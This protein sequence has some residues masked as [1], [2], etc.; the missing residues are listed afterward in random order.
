MY[1]W[2]WEVMYTYRSV[3]IHG[4]LE[5]MILTLLTVLIGTAGGIIIAIVRRSENP[6]FSVMAKIGIDLIRA[7]PILVLLIWA[8]YVLP[9]L[10][11][12]KL[13]PFTTATFTL[14]LHLSAFVAETI[15]AGVESIP[16]HQFESAEALGLTPLQTMTQI[17]APQAIRNILPNVLGLYVTQIKNTSLTSV[18]AVNELLHVSN[19][20][21][22]ASYRPLEI[23]TVVACIYVALIEPCEIGVHFLE[24]KFRKNI[25][26]W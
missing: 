16:K 7:L 26:V 1:T 18:I 15:R 13:S 8:F 17:I 9:L 23:Y 6:V 21:I 3:F 24:R 10:T 4:A 14:S 5:T 22:S 20:L 2:N 12:W 25:N 11:G 19:T